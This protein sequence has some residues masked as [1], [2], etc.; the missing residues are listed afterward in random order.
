MNDL[1]VDAD[2]VAGRNIAQKWSTFAGQIRPEQYGETSTNPALFPH[3]ANVIR[4]SGSIFNKWKTSGSCPQRGLLCFHNVGAGKT[5]EMVGMIIMARRYM[6]EAIVCITAMK[7]QLDSLFGSD[8][9]KDYNTYFS[10]ADPEMKRLKA[11]AGLPDAIDEANGYQILNR[12]GGSRTKVYSEEDSKDPCQTQ[13]SVGVEASDDD[14][15]E[16]EEDYRKYVDVDEDEEESQQPS[17]TKKNSAVAPLPRMDWKSG[18]ITTERPKECNGNCHYNVADSYWLPAFGTEDNPGVIGIKTQALAKEV[19]MLKNLQNGVFPTR[20]RNAGPLVLHGGRPIIYIFDEGHNLY[21]PPPNDSE[22]HSENFEA[23]HDYFCS[24]ESHTNSFLIL[25]TAT[26]AFTVEGV[27]KFS[28]LLSFRDQIAEIEIIERE[29]KLKGKLT[30]PILKR[31]RNLMRG[32][33]DAWQAMRNPYIYPNLHFVGAEDSTSSPL[34]EI[35]AARH[36]LEQSPKMLRTGWID[37]LRSFYGEDENCENPKGG[38]KKERKLSCGELR[39]L[40]SFNPMYDERN[41]DIEKLIKSNGNPNTKVRDGLRRQRRS[42]FDPKVGIAPQCNDGLEAYSPKLAMLRDEVR[43]NGGK[44][45]VSCMDQKG[46]YFP[47]GAVAAMLEK[48]L[49]YELLDISPIKGSKCQEEANRKLRESLLKAGPKK[50]Y[51]CRKI[52]KDSFRHTPHY[53]P[54]T[55]REAKLV[56]NSIKTFERGN[57][58]AFNMEENVNGEY[59]KVVVVNDNESTEGV[60]I[61]QLRHIHVFDV[62]PLDSVAQIVGRGQRP[63]VFKPMTVPDF[64]ASEQI[65]LKVG[66]QLQGMLASN[67]QMIMRTRV[68]EYNLLLQNQIQGSRHDTLRFSK[69]LARFV[70]GIRVL[71]YATQWEEARQQQLFRTFGLRM[72]AKARLLDPNKSWV[73]RLKKHL[74]QI[75]YDSSGGAT[76]SEASRALS[77][78]RRYSRSDSLESSGVFGNEKN[79]PWDGFHLL[80]NI[81]AFIDVTRMYREMVRVSN[82]C[83][84]ARKA[85]EQFGQMSGGI[86]FKAD[87]DVSDAGSVD[88]DVSYEQHLIAIDQALSGDDDQP[89]WGRQLSA[90]H[91]LASHGWWDHMQAVW[92]GISVD[93]LLE[94]KEILKQMEKEYGDA[95]PPA[96]EAFR[97]TIGALLNV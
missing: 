76:N 24:D 83:I 77:E 89:A 37:T 12:I 10:S 69:R 54:K 32:K 9:K 40:G 46:N 62:L 51:F 11:E 35:A 71:I 63:Y 49:G 58:G 75:D 85:H 33:I 30:D 17:P 59:L 38:S 57:M 50:R 28:R 64:L 53:V 15:A 60:S 72:A 2:A 29:Y 95:A 52:S 78:L 27:L 67:L 26:P 43:K 13:R 25:M 42:F 48:C 7:K 80:K 79:L 88:P 45:F 81:S 96:Y 14:D 68:S 31:W 5:A 20:R 70:E 91:A 94:R 1:S 6:P 97:E 8:L 61:T 56:W 55:P 44:H 3:Q 19:R 41:A 39:Y 84:V 65:S 4:W 93:D 23:L 66:Q 47:S 74:V 21:K 86:D 16:L 34:Q 90:Q 22:N 92:K 73:R 87:C 18:K 82:N 36:L